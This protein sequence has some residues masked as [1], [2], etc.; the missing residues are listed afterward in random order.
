MRSRSR[1]T[2]RP[3]DAFRD[4]AGAVARVWTD[5]RRPTG[6][7]PDSGGG[8]HLEAG[9]HPDRCR[10]AGSALGADD[11]PPMWSPEQRR[12]REQLGWSCTQT[13]R[14]CRSRGSCLAPHGVGTSQSATMLD[15]W[16][17]RL[18][19]SCTAGGRLGEPGSRLLNVAKVVRVGP[20]TGPRAPPTP[21][22]RAR[23]A[24]EQVLVG[25]RRSRYPVDATRA[26]RGSFAVHCGTCSAMLVP[27]S[28]AIGNTRRR[29]GRGRRWRS[30]CATR[31]AQTACGACAPTWQRRTAKRD[32][33][34]ARRWAT[35]FRLGI[36]GLMRA[37]P[38]VRRTSRFSPKPKWWTRHASCSTSWGHLVVDDGAQPSGAS[39]VRRVAARPGGS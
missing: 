22:L 26:V 13:W 18:E 19:R 24:P 30:G 36:D 27:M 23:V 8:R 4:D 29:H 35:Q 11:M 5:A 34:S 3:V 37:T 6:A 33:R 10:G 16:W 2:S 1:G 21:A 28:L 15:S 39:R 38:A 9:R 12:R 20:G 31:C 7:T 17:T 14:S 25:R 32:M